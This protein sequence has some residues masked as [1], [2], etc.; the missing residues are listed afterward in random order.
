LDQP[1]RLALLSPLLTAGLLFTYSR[2]AF[3][4]TLVALV[5]LALALRAL[6]S[7][8]VP[9]AAL[10]MLAGATAIFAVTR[11]SFW[12]RVTVESAGLGYG[13]QYTLAV[14]HLVAR[15]GEALEAKA[16]IL[17]TGDAVWTA[18]RFGIAAR[19]YD[20]E[21][22]REAE[23]PVIRVPR[24][25]PPGARLEVEVPLTA[26]NA[27][28]RH[29]LILDLFERSRGLFSAYGVPPAVLPVSVSL[30]GTSPPYAFEPRAEVWRRGRF[31]LWRIAA[32]IWREHPLLGAGPDNYRWLHAM[33]GG[34]L[35]TGDFTRSADSTYLEI[36]ANTGTLGLLTYLTTLLAAGRCA[37]RRLLPIS[38][39]PVA[40]LGMLV[41]MTVH[42]M[43]EYV[44]RFSG[45]FLLFGL[46]VGLAS[47]ACKRS[48]EWGETAR[49]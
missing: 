16:S 38:A 18:E 23:G 48:P 4:A 3:L 47:S 12:L 7:A 22:R 25:V 37:W 6:G 36:A 24:S 35:V 20:P 15:P 26:P 10:A 32:L 43:V 45:H 21:G 33:R 5:V 29:V 28:G 9:T 42:G 30:A 49:S 27:E 40:A 19:W 44:L 14:S 1:R 13:A 41:A 8:R 2:G 39:P 31:E 34:W 11:P 46:V 17:N